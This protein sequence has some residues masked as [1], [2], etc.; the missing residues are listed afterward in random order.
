LSDIIRSRRTFLKTALTTSGIIINGSL[1]LPGK[2]PAHAAPVSGPA[3]TV[4]QH[5]GRTVILIDGKP[6]PGIAI[7][8]PPKWG[9]N[10]EK[11]SV[12][13]CVDAG[14]GIVLVDM[15]GNWTG[16][17]KWEFSE[18]LKKLDEA[19]A[20]NPDI[21]LIARV[22]V[23]APGW[24]RAANPE[25]CTR[26]NDSTGTEYAACMG[27]EKWIAD[28]S[29]HLAAL[30][31]AIEESPSGSRIIGYALMCAHG[32]EWAY[33]GA[34]EGR[35]GDYSAPA[36]RYFRE[37]LRRKYGNRTWIEQVQV[38]SEKERGRS[39]PG[40]LC[41]PKQDSLAIDY[42]LCFSDMTADNILAL[43][44][45]VKRETGGRRLTGA[46]YGYLT[47]KIGLVNSIATTGRLALRRLL[48]SPDI[49]FFT[50]FPSYDVREPGQ[51]AP[52]LLPVESIQAAGKLVFDE[53]DN[54]THLTVD[55]PPIRLELARD[56]RDPVTGPQLWSGMWN[57]WPLESEQIAV[58]VLRREFAHHI[59][60]GASYWWYEMAGGWY[61]PAI[62]KDFAREQEIARQALDWDMSS[63][64]QAA[65]LVC[66]ESPA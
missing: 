56:Q 5:N 46:F 42:E 66:G 54:R 8:G 26:Y 65:G 24:W 34:G 3:V 40:L 13:A 49:D 31:H 11:N 39:L 22:H 55:P 27:S 9:R 17:G 23:D 20:M 63:N 6:V 59:V 15:T 16:P 19:R 45:V 41:D 28:S 12:R 32:G 18:A 2:N 60:R 4:G 47:W 14:I 33:T 38:P 53:C 37:W 25:E 44:R 48:E 52:I 21:W 51:A 7:L 30:V 50:A 10:A 36:L 58:D 35:I 43:C 64:S 57:L 61:S 29:E 62:L 1:I